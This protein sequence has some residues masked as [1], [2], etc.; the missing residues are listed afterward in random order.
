MDDFVKELVGGV[1]S[2]GGAKVKEGEVDIEN[3]AVKMGCINMDKHVL[4]GAAGNCKVF[5]GKVEV[6]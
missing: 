1:G 6:W 3:V 5:R 4:V 2:V